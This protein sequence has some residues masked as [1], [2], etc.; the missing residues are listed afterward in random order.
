MKAATK[1]YCKSKILQVSLFNFAILCYL[2]YSRKLDAREKNSVLQYPCWCQHN[3]WLPI[4]VLAL[5]T[6]NTDE[7]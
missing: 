4:T 1:C 2:R 6:D 7:K 3:T 5:T